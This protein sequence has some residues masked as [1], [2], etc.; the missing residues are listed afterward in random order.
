MKKLSLEEILEGI[1]DTRRSNSVMYP[2]RDVL[3][4]MLTAIICGATSYLRI[5]MFARS[6]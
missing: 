2:L 1:E 4:I 3:F 5:E 6:R